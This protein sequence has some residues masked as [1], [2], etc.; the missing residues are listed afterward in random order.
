MGPDDDPRAALEQLKEFVRDIA[1]ADKIDAH[2]F[3]LVG[4]PQETIDGE[5]RELCEALQRQS[6]PFPRSTASGLSF[7]LRELIRERIR[8]IE[9]NAS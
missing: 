4:E 7:A 5:T 6:P 3:R 8:E 9:D 2:A 1:P